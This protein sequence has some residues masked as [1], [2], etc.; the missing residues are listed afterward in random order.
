MAQVII[1][2]LDETVVKALKARAALK[3]RPLEQ[4]LRDILAE[5]CKL[6]PQDRLALATQ[7]RATQRT[8]LDSGTETLI[9]D[10][11]DRR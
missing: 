4:E 9:R 10:E 5:A 8:V 2:N 6:S 3:G 1:R 7:I 11:R